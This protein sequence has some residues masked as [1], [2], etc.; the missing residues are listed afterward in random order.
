MNH[1]LTGLYCTTYHS[2]HGACQKC[3]ECQEWIEPNHWNDTCEGYK[4][5]STPF[6]E[7]G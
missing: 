5:Q 6:G 3:S 2:T 1:K 7:K 4:P